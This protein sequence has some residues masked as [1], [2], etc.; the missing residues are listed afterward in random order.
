MIWVIGAKGMLGRELCRRLATA[1]K[2]TIETDMEI[3]ILD[4]DALQGFA[5][6]I[7]KSRQS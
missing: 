3:D 1:G 6:K 7:E 5:K 4:R 2:T